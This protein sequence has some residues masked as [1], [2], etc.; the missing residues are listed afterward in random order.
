MDIFALAM[1]SPIVLAIL[2]A[3]YKVVKFFVIDQPSYEYRIMTNEY[4]D[5]V[6]TVI[7]KGEK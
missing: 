4:G 6:E 2:A 7:S 3:L 1:L 5:P